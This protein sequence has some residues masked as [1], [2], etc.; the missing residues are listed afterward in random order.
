MIISDLNYL[1]ATATEV[2][3]GQTVT[4]NKDLFS[5]ATSI[6]NFLSAS[7]IQ[8][9]FNVQKNVESVTNLQGNLAT[10]YFDNEAYGSDTLAEGEFAQL[11]IEGLLSSQVGKFVSAAE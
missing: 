5:V 9:V 3:G 10:L 11:T 6:S 8:Q 1:E 2:L 7:D 4:F